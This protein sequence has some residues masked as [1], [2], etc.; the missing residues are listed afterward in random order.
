LSALAALTAASALALSACGGGGDD[1]TPAPAPAPTPAP[2]PSGPSVD[3]GPTA[4]PGRYAVAIQQGDAV[5]AG[6]YLQGANGQ[7]LVVIAGEDERA[8]AVYTKAAGDGQTWQAAGSS[9]TGAVTFAST[10]PVV[11]DDT[12]LAELA[13]DY[14]TLLGDQSAATLRVAASGAITAGNGACQISGQLGESALPNAFT[15]EISAKS[16]AGLP[17]QFKG[18]AVVDADYAP[19][20]MRLISADAN[21]VVEL[22]LH[23]D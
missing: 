14:R 5:L 8:A 19:A 10:T 6:K 11:A 15:A 12:A 1:D 18:Y 16:C 23:A 17:A 4:G 13:G 20:R 7:G 2:A 3:V 22:W 21:A 9:S